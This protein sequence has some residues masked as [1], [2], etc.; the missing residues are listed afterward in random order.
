MFRKISI[1]NLLIFI[2]LFSFAVEPSVSI[3]KI[4]ED[5]QL[6]RP[7]QIDID[8]KHENNLDAEINTKKINAENDYFSIINV[9]EENDLVSTSFNLTIIPF[10]L[11]VSTLTAVNVDFFEQDKLVS[12]SK[13]EDIEFDIK[14]TKAK[15]KAKGLID[16]YSPYKPFN[17]ILMLMWLSAIILVLLV[18]YFISKRFRKTNEKIAENINYDRLKNISP[19]QMAYDQLSGLTDSFFWQEKQY[20]KYFYVL[21]GILR[22]YLTGTFEVN[23]YQKNTTDLLRKLRTAISDKKVIMNTREFLVMCDLV[24]F[25]KYIPTEQYRDKA[26]VLIRQIIEATKHFHDKQEE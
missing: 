9:D 23:A 4:P 5:I 6:A 2:S 26:V 18:V 15:V 8:A 24:K 25:S 19:H 7:F 14:P 20:K 22:K 1:F 16:I 10:V 17:I 12:T 11:G 21:S 3:G 13:L